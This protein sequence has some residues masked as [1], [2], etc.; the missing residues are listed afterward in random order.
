M[1]G[2]GHDEGDE[3]KRIKGPG[4]RGKRGFARLDDVVP[5]WLARMCTDLLGSQEVFFIYYYNDQLSVDC[6]LRGVLCTE[7]D[8]FSLAGRRPHPR[9][10]VPADLHA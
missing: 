8:L 3:R 6:T 9:R 1:Y 2:L 7:K 10:S 4:V 5:R